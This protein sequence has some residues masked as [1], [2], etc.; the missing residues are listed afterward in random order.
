MLRL[1]KSVMVLELKVHF[2]SYK[3]SILEY[4]FRIE[5][6]LNAEMWQINLLE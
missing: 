3:N 5:T 2:P 4:L 6:K 1:D